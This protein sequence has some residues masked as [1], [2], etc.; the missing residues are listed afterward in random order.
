MRYRGTRKLNITTLILIAILA[1]F[2]LFYKAPNRNFNFLSHHKATE[3]ASSQSQPVCNA[4]LVI[5]GDSFVCQFSDG[6]EEHIRLIGIDAPESRRNPK[7]ERDS[8][9]SGQDIKTIIT[10][11]KKGAQITKSYLKRG[12][13]VN[14]ELDVQPRDKYERL[15][16][17]VYLPD[18][19][20]LNALLVREGYAQVMTV[21]PNVRHQDM[22]LN[23][24]RQARE[25]GKGLWER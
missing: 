20:M 11:G 24:Q 13:P 1:I 7:A 10:L 23:L 22:F 9:R 4:V 25:Q 14:L 5:D 12:T 17:Y 19:T 2:Y 3:T 8:E 16:A 6:K 18:G 15:L 21:P